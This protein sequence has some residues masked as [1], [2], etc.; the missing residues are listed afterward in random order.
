ME[1]RVNPLTSAKIMASVDGTDLRSDAT[2][3]AV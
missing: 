1:E 2:K 3:R